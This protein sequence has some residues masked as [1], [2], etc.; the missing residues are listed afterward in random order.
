MNPEEKSS[1]HSK[2]SRG[3]INCPD[4]INSQ[5]AALK[6]QNRGKRQQDF[7]SGNVAVVKVSVVQE[8]MEKYGECRH[9]L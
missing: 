6:P 3:I 9:S 4:E 5:Q 8:Y 1:F 2:Q 7:K